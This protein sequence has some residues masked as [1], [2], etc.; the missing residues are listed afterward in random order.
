MLN[1][2]NLYAA[3][4]AAAAS[5]P[6][7]LSDVVPSMPY[8]QQSG[9][10]G[11]LSVSEHETCLQGVDVDAA[12]AM[13]FRQKSC[14]LLSVSEENVKAF[15]ETDAAPSLPHRQSSLASNSHHT[16]KSDS[17]TSSSEPVPEYLQPIDVESKLKEL[18][19]KAEEF[20][21]VVDLRDR[22]YGMRTYKQCFIGSEAV[23]RMI[24]VGLAKDRDEAVEL[25]GNWMKFLGLFRHV[26]D[27]HDFKDKHLFYK[28]GGDSHKNRAEKKKNAAPAPARIGRPWY[29]IRGRDALTMSGLSLLEKNATEQPDNAKST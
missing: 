1:E 4:T 5:S 11:L 29:S 20:K 10:T 13:P 2:E 26:C 6:P 28:F 24:E 12:P 3:T 22:K 23:D 25:G 27:D 16:K 8:R 17:S 7:S 19:E 21:R 9:G 18:T 14:A 15:L